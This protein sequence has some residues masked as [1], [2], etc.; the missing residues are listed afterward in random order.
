[1]SDPTSAPPGW[2]DDGRGQQRYWDG[3]QWTE[4]TAP[5]YGAQDA[6]RPY[7]TAAL[8]GD[9]SPG[10]SPYADTT[11]FAGL[12]TDGPAGSGGAPPA[13]YTGYAPFGAAPGAPGAPPEPG[14]T[15]VLGIVALVIAAIGFVFAVIPFVQVVGLILLPIAFVL[16]IIALFLKGRKWPAITGLILSVVGGIIGTIV[17]AVVALGVFGQIVDSGVIQ[18]EIDRQLEEEF[19]EPTGPADEGS[20]EESGDEAGQGQVLAF[21]ETMVWSNGVSMTVSAPEPFTPSDLSAG[22]DQAENIVF[23]LTIQ[24]DSGENVQ[25]V[26]FSQLS[27]GGTEATRIFDVGAEGGQVGIPPTTAIL[28][29]ES[30]TW[31]EAWSVADSGSLTMQ[32]APSFEYEDV[33]FTNVPQ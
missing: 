18:D 4:H 13:G 9:S 21:G 23:T 6:T 22:A 11:P 31:S 28:P 8:A 33:I 16:A 2:Y 25:P 3:T 20:G 32:T 15:N 29:G 24:N 10:S 19:G 17:F 7:D 30:I 26:V 1:M 27:S 5:L 14:G 12:P